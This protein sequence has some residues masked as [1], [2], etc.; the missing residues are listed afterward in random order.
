MTVSS[1]C[2][3]GRPWIR[4]TTT[5][6][7][8]SARRALISCIGL[9]F[10]AA[11][12]P[13]PATAHEGRATICIPSYR[14]GPCFR[15]PPETSYEGEGGPSYRFGDVVP[16]KGRVSP[17]HRGRIEILGRKAPDYELR[18]LM[19]DFPFPLWETVATVPL[20]GRG[21]FRYLWRTTRRDADQGRPYQFRVRLM[22]HAESRI[23]EV[24]VL[25]GE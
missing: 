18:R 21:R 20:D 16:V 14:G 10:V 13:L 15:P 6:Q 1:P 4:G 22:G 11:G 7:G 8:A 9:A 19:P 5:R 2:Q 3:P 24:Y 12:V 17:R 25:L 23:Q